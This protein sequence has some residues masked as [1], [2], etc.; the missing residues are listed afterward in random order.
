MKSN[1]SLEN[2]LWDVENLEE[3]IVRGMTKS[4][5][6]LKEEI[7]KPLAEGGGRTGILYKIPGIQAFVQAS[8]I[9]EVPQPRSGHLRDSWIDYPVSATESV[10]ESTE[11]Y[12]AI[13][14]EWLQREITQ[15]V[16]ETFRPRFFLNIED[17]VF[18]R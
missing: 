1:L 13:L 11:P 12:A 2:P 18:G 5:K 6:E 14:E 9:Y 7:R 3:R 15:R 8:A 17:A 4:R 10:V 16:T